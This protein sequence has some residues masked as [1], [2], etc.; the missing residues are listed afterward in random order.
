MLLAKKL[1]LRMPIIRL[2]VEKTVL[3]DGLALSTANNNSFS[4]LKSNSDNTFDQDYN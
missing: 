2:T 1:C 4:L 3:T